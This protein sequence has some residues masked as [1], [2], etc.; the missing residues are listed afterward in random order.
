MEP[1]G[2]MAFD[3]DTKRLILARLTRAFGLEAFLAKKYSSE[4]R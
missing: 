4:K 3:N 1:P 2:V